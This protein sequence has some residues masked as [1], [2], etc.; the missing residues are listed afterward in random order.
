[1][2]PSE[3]VKIG[4]HF[5]CTLED[6]GVRS[7]DTVTWSCGYVGFHSW[8]HVTCGLQAGQGC[9]KAYVSQI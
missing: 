7:A 3:L 6:T 1:M 4:Q 8:M 2:G 5:H 9:F